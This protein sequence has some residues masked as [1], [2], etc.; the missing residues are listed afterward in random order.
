VRQDAPFSDGRCAAAIG[1]STR[2][3]LGRV[4]RAARAY[5]FSYTPWTY[6]SA[7]AAVRGVQR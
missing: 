4:P 3:P 1:V 6:E 2:E 7:A 5:V